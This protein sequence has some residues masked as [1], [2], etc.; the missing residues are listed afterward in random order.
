MDP[1][2]TTEQREVGRTDSRP[3]QEKPVSFKFGAVRE[4]VQREPNVQ[5]SIEQVRSEVANHPRMDREVSRQ[6]EKAVDE[7][8]A[9]QQS[10]REVAAR[11]RLFKHCKPPSER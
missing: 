6:V 8:R 10:G 7:A 5:R 2:V 3:A 1:R 9:L 11:E 4:Q